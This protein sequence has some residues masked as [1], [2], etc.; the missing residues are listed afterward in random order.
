MCGTTQTIKDQLNTLGISGNY[1]RFEAIKRN[2][3]R[4]NLEDKRRNR[5]MEI[6]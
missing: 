3:M 5:V 4:Q 2:K 6:V 1:E